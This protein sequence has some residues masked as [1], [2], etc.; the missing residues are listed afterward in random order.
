MTV[1]A[2][3]NNPLDVVGR[4]VLPRANSGSGTE[5]EK[6]DQRSCFITLIIFAAVRPESRWVGF[7][8]QSSRG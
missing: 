5:G 8:M 6:G 3:A 1:A 2:S 4:L 7:K